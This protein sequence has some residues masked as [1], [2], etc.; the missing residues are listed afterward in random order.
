M[1]AFLYVKLFKIQLNFDV[2][3]YHV[4]LASFSCIL[5]LHIAPLSLLATHIPILVLFFT[6][7]NVPFI[8]LPTSSWLLYFLYRHFHSSIMFYSMFLF[9]YPYC[10]IFIFFSFSSLYIPFFLYRS[11]Y[12]Y[13]L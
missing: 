2:C 12:F 13:S 6:V 10:F 1:H 3:L 4:F 5:Y 9:I 11:S 7:F 8:Y